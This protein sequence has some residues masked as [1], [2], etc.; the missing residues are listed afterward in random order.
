MRFPEAV[1][2]ADGNESPVWARSKRSGGGMGGIVVLLLVLLALFGGLTIGLAVKEKSFAKGGETLDKWS[3]GAM[4]AVGMKAKKADDA[5][6]K[7]GDKVEAA[8]AKV[9]DKAEAA[10]DKVEAAADKT[11]ANAKA[12]ADKVTAAPAKK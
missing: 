6:D 1:R 11:V 10:G 2:M 12:G 3:H 4:A 7:A 9:E 8:A 5:A